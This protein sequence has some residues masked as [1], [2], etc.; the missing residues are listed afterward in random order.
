MDIWRKNYI[1]RR[2]EKQEFY[3]GY[4]A[5]S[6]YADYVVLLNVQTESNSAT[7]TEQGIRRTQRIKTYGAFPV[8]T[9]DQT[10][11]VKG[12]MLYFNGK[13]YECVAS[14]HYE[15]T[16]LAHYESEF[17][18]VSEAIEPPTVPIGG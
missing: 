14:V 2:H 1:L 7:P 12:D 4:A 13:W 5:S 16:P 18:S 8:T 17:V 6:G 15:H 9:A 3:R 10:E 11:G